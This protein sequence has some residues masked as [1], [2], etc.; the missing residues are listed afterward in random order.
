MKLYE[1]VKDRLNSPEGVVSDNEMLLLNRRD[2][3]FSETS[4]GRTFLKM[5]NSERVTY[6]MYAIVDFLQSYLCKLRPGRNVEIYQLSQSM[7]LPSLAVSCYIDRSKNS[8]NICAPRGVQSVKAIDNF[9]RDL[10][11]QFESSINMDLTMKHIAQDNETLKIIFSN[12]SSEAEV[13]SSLKSFESVSNGL[14]LI[15]GY[16]RSKAPNCGEIMLGAKLNLHN[17]LAGFSIAFAL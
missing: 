16:G 5:F 14:L 8:L 1:L 17:S 13:V 2:F 6:E 4:P 10:Y 9:A 15:K 3:I 11:Q 12:A 7:T